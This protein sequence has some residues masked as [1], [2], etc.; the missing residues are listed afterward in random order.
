MEIRF[1]HKTEKEILKNIWKTVFNEDEF[2]LNYKFSSFVAENTVVAVVDEEIAG[3]VHFDPCIMSDNSLSAYLNGVSV[4]EKYR[5]N[6]IAS[7]M[8]CF[9]HSYLKDHNYS[10]CFLKPAISNFYEKFGYKTVF[11]PQIVK[12]LPEKK[13]KYTL[14]DYNYE[15][16]FRKKCFESDLYLQRTKQNFEKIISLYK[17]YNGD[18]LCFKDKEELAGY[19]I[20][21]P[22]NK[23]IVIEEAVSLKE[24]FLPSIMYY[25]DE[26]PLINELPVMV[27]ELNN[28]FNFK[29]PFI[30]VI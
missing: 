5:N 23:K 2:Y 11:S 22:E 6:N 1:A 15:K 13:C 25:F 8:L 7:K 18:I 30:K 12:S 10:F 26:S 17:N 14:T 27:K 3:M 20:Y 19:I 9:L 29:N 24:D 16:I 4:L 21:F 28:K